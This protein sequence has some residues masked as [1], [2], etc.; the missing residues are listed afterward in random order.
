MASDESL[1]RFADL[2]VRPSD[3]PYSA[4]HWG[5]GDELGTLVRAT[6]E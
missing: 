6:M 3:P 4:W 2:P 1:P 5:E